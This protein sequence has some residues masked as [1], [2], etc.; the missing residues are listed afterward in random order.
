MPSPNDLS[1]KFDPITTDWTY[2]RGLGDRKGIE[3][4]T[5]T[6]GKT[7]IDRTNE[8]RSWVDV[9]YETVRKGVKVFA[10]ANNHHGRHAPATIRLFPELW[11]GKGLPEI[12]KHF[13]EP[14]KERTLFDL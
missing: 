7:V 4:I 10:Y 9:C 11:R 8:I 1:E 2:I 13:S 14:L 3:R 5:T 12:G 6:W